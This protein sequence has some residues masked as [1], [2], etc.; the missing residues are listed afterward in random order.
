LFFAFLVV[1]LTGRKHAKGLRVQAEMAKEFYEKEKESIQK[2]YELEMENR[3]KARKTYSDAVIK[4]E[5]EYEQNKEE[6]THSKKER[7]KRMVS[8]AKNKPEDVDAIL[9][10]ELG[11][12]KES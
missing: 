5:Q 2:A 11:I 6:L 9:E 8:K 7:I 10:R 3:E 4:I 12:R 1:Y